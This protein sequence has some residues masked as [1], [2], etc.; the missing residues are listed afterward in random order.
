[1]VSQCDVITNIYPFHFRCQGFFLALE[2]EKGSSERLTV[3]SDFRGILETIG[4]SMI[5]C[6]SFISAN[7]AEAQFIL[8]SA[9]SAFIRA[10]F[11]LSAARINF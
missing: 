10:Q 4:T 7:S 11:G 3:G 2:M 6:V 9:I 5:L 8:L 1:M